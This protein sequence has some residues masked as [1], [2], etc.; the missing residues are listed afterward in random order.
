MKYF[1]AFILCIFVLGGLCISKYIY[2]ETRMQSEMKKLPTKYDFASYRILCDSIEKKAPI[3]I[4]REAKTFAI[5]LKK[6]YRSSEINYACHYVF[7]PL[8]CGMGCDSG[9]VVDV[10]TGRAYPLPGGVSDPPELEDYDFTR[11][12]FRKDSRLIILTG[13][14]NEVNTNPGKL[15]RHYYLIENN[16]FSKIGIDILSF[17]KSVKQ[18]VSQYLVK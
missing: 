1:K 6:A 3:I 14:I 12:E 17:D 9:G 7:V 11:I 15:V 13:N 18:W 16:G 2:C 10:L 4:P 8:N 5:D